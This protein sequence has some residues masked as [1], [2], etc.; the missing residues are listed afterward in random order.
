MRLE[1]IKLSGFKSFVDSTTISFNSD[2]VGIVGPNGCGKSN[3]IDAVRWVMGESSAKNLRGDQMADVIFNGS[4]TRKPVSQAVVELIFDNTDGTIIGEYAGNRQLALK[5]QVNREGQSTYFLN[6]TRCRR[7]DITDLFLGTGLGPRSYAIIEQGTI[8]RLVE[9]KPEELR[10][11]LEEAAGISKYK[12]RRRDT[13]NRMRRTRENL[14]RV[15]DLCEE[16]E[17]QCRHLKRQASTA[18]KYKT[19]KAEERQIK[20]Q[21][22]AL[23]WQS[24]DVLDVDQNKTMQGLQTRV[25][26]LLATQRELE[27]NIEQQRNSHTA[28]S[29]TWN[30]VQAEFYAVGSEISK[31][32]QALQHKK[33]E[34]NQYRTLREHNEQLIESS[35]QEFAEEKSKLQRA[36]EQIQLTERSLGGTKDKEAALAISLNRAEDTMTSWQKTWD[37]FTYQV[38]EP[39]RKID[40]EKAKI[41]QFERHLIQ[42]SQRLESAVS[43][44][45]S[46]Q[47]TMQTG[48][49]GDIQQKHDLLDKTYQAEQLATE[50]LQDSISELRTMAHKHNESLTKNRADHALLSG[51]LA[52]IE[53]LQQSSLGDSHNKVQYWLETFNLAGALTLVQSLNV[54][55][56]WEMAVETVLGSALQAIYVDDF[57]AALIGLKELR[58]G[59]ITLLDKRHASVNQNAKYASTALATLIDSEAFPASLF[60]GVH[61]AETVEQA[62]RLIVSLGE[63]ESVITKQ[64]IWLRPGSV[65]LRNEGDKESALALEK[66]KKS[67]VK[68][69]SVLTVLI[70]E[71]E[72]QLSTAQ[73]T[74]STSEK[75]RYQKNQSQTVLAKQLSSLA[76][77]V[78]EKQ[79]AINQAKQ[80]QVAIEEDLRVALKEQ[81]QDQALLAASR[82]LL[83]RTINEASELDAKR[84]QLQQQRDEKK[85]ALDKA[86]LESQAKREQAH[87]LMLGLESNR[88]NKA[89]TTHRLKTI[90]E[91]MRH[92]ET[93]YA[94]A[95]DVLKRSDEPLDKQTLALDSLLQ[96]KVEVE[97]KLAEERRLLEQ[98]EHTIRRLESDRSSSEQT[99]QAA[100]EDISSAKVNHQEVLV[101][102]QT[103]VEQLQ[104]SGVNLEET[105]SALLGDAEESAWQEQVNLLV[106]KIERL[107]PINLTAIEEFETQSERKTYLDSQ[108]KDLLDSLDTLESAIEKIDKES[109]LLFRQTFDKV[110]KGFERRFPKLFGGGNAYLQLTGGDILETGVTVMARPPGKRNSSIHLLSGGEKALTAVALVF[111]IFDLNPAPFCMLDEVDA[112]LDEANVGRF[113]ELVREMSEQVQM[114]LITH[115]KATM[116]MAKQ[117]S[118]VTMKEPGV[119]RIVSVDL[120]EAAKMVAN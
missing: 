20:A 74:L 40:V 82:S 113:G 4:S 16:I 57:D 63:M 27:K 115:N 11:F 5:R 59:D 49:V 50:R 19:L 70:A 14:E 58:D 54:K 46:L 75:N 77:E 26:L 89:L 106:M 35:Q 3:V 48:D 92:A 33:A 105:L 103:L 32:E 72:E 69:L 96:K 36:E 104:E 78:S 24:L 60:S 88:S 107:G 15:A 86:R 61:F 8:S 68:K 67:L 47:Q 9:A 12:E 97:G 114:I 84:E 10:V 110:N 66:E 43:E 100:R 119:S 17:K 13:E 2:M 51:R 1:K 23:K 120:D 6:G 73:A 53:V 99:V 28:Q 38:A 65:S 22:L 90:E 117:L 64:G 52:S 94:E 56:G 39:K 62:Q 29:E 116:E 81:E 111:A 42:L 7:K 80:R 95:C 112:P 109:R 79:S 21:L 44:K 108:Q 76:L 71:E 25:E 34:L 102:K 98:F 31:A 101:R 18:E 37:E 45:S 30:K 41:A 118:G 85:A 93:Q 83:E 55:E 87:Q 91:K